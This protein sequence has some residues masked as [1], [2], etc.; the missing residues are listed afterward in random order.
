[1]PTWKGHRPEGCLYL[2]KFFLLYP[3]STVIN[4]NRT[5]LSPA[6][7]STSTP[8]TPS[9]PLVP[10]ELR[11]SPTVATPSPTA[12]TPDLNM[13]LALSTA[14]GTSTRMA[15]TV[16]W[17]VLTR[18]MFTRYTSTARTQSPL[19][20]RASTPVF[21]SLLVLLSTDCLRTLLLLLGD[22]SR[23]ILWIKRHELL[24]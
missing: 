6:K 24:H 13:S 2:S 12:S 14:S 23:W 18:K 10:M 21:L 17:P 4:L 20:D 22:I 16:S 15:L 5:P 3:M 8:T 7:S 9:E 11:S 1:M 19:V